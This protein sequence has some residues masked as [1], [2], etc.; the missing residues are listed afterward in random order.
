MD[1]YLVSAI[2]PVYKV[3]EYL[4]QC[5]ESIVNQTYKNIE[6][7]LVDD[8]SPDNCPAI[9]DVW[10]KKDK[11][12]KVVHKKNGGLSDARNAG[13]RVAT[14]EYFVFIDSDDTVSSEYIEKMMCIMQQ[15]NADIVEC[16]VNY[17]SE[18]GNLL[19]K[20]G[21]SVER[22][23]YTRM[24]ALK[25]L[26]Y[27]R[28]IYQT[29]W[30]KLYKKSVI[31]NI[32]FIVGKCNEDEFW[33]FRVFDRAQTIVAISDVLY[34]YLQRKSSIMGVG[35]TLKRLDGLQARVQRTEYLQKYDELA[36]FTREYIWHDYLYHYQCAIKWLHDEEQKMVTDYIE[37]RM[38]DEENIHWSESSLKY[39]LWFRLFRKWPF[40][41]A[42]FRNCLGIGI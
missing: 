23:K 28:E 12:I 18:E 22:K 14:G 33:T 15:E 16:G 27:E 40:T 11:R 1:K 26:V 41:V 7:I 4:N 31:E 2:V 13:M 10:C 21:C 24:E 3:E 39:R 32:N 19:R 5:I 20:R 25:E 29:V 8:G 30:N 37:K 42:K 38:K 36:D 17:I 35:Y 9:C 34:Y 6:I